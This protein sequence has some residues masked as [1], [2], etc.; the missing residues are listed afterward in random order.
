[1]GAVGVRPFMYLLTPYTM[2]T[3]NPPAVDKLREAEKLL[4]SVGFVP[5]LWHI[6]DVRKVA[7]E[8]DLGELTDEECLEILDG[9]IDNHDADTGIDWSAL[10]QYASCYVSQK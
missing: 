6:D 4:R 10:G 9:V 7:T 3:D 8:N 5:I 1:M 2:S